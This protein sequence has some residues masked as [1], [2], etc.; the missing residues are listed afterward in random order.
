ME[1][2]SFDE[3]IDIAS[4]KETDI[5]KLE[6][7]KKYFLENVDFDYFQ[8]LAFDAD[9]LSYSN[10][11]IFDSNEEKEDEITKLE[12]IFGN[13]FAFSQSDRTALIN[14]LGKRVE[15]LT[16][17]IRIGESEFTINTPSYDG[18]IYD[19]IKQLSSKGTVE[20]NGLIK[21]GICSSFS[22]FIKKYCDSLG[23]PCKIAGTG[24]HDF[25]LININGEVKV[26]DPARML[27]VRDDYKNPNNENV[28]DWWNTSIDKMYELKPSERT[29]IKI[30]EKF[31]DEEINSLNY[32][33]KINT[34]FGSH[35]MKV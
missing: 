13:G 8:E 30:D 17:K 27:G 15:P 3:L 23:I 35:G 28:N 4:K 6:V 10:K 25:C 14:L 26:F 9:K 19:C 33:E 32:K 11:T 1:V 34:V 5:E 31:L 18:S 20:V 16:K 2:R 7:L 24:K 22:L 29:I 12:K 21:K